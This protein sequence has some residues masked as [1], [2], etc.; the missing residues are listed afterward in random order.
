[1]TTNSTS[2]TL[3]LALGVLGQAVYDVEGV[4]F[5]D[6]LDNFWHDPGHPYTTT[7]V[8]FRRVLVDCCLVPSFRSSVSPGH[9]RCRGPLRQGRTV[10]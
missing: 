1:M 7:F 9:R 4:T 5:Q 6:R 3:A 2:G 10:T 8:A